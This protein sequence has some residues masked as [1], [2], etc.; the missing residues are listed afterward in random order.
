[1]CVHSVLD[2]LHIIVI[3]SLHEKKGDVFS[4]SLSHTHTHTH[5]Q[6]Q[7]IQTSPCMDA[8]TCLS[9]GCYL[10]LLFRQCSYLSAPVYHLLP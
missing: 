8:H 6:T 2:V 4:L 7:H 1:M 9:N 3:Y 5:K 10:L